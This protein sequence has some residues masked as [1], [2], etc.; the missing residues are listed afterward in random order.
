MADHTSHYNLT[1]PVYGETVDVQDINGNMDT[2]DAIIYDADQYAQSRVS[3]A[4]DDTHNYAVGDFCIHENQLYKCISATT[5]TW[6]STKWTLTNLGDNLTDA[7]KTATRAELTAVQAISVLPDAY[8]ED[9]TYNVGDLC[10]NGALFR[11]IATT[12][13]DWDSTKW[14]L[15]S[16]ENEFER[17]HIWSLYETITADGIESRYDRELPVNCSAVFIEVFGKTGSANDSIQVYA[18]FPDNVWRRVGVGTN[19]INTAGDR[20]SQF[21]YMSDGNY[22]QGQQANPA[23]ANQGMALQVRQNGYL[24]TSDPIKKLRINTDTN[25]FPTGSTITI[26]VRR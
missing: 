4:Y 20:Y 3:D 16:L 9:M 22:W 1:K 15:T 14:V 6:D 24:F 8:D 17:K 26:Y 7:K 5:G 25:P 10:M 13:G 12:T 2:L 19:G 21:W 23:A 11:C 18:S